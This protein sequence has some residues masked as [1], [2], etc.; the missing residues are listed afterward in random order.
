MRNRLSSVLVA[1]A[2]LALPASQ[3]PLTAG[4]KPMVA[5]SRGELIGRLDRA[6]F[7]RVEALRTDEDATSVE[8]SFE[9]KL[10]RGRVEVRLIDPAG[11][12]GRGSVAD[13]HLVLE[14]GRLPV[15]S[16]SGGKGGEGGTVRHLARRI[17]RHEATGTWAIRYAGLAPA[18]G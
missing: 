7:H 16:D 9:A 8:V 17:H 3:V 13:G 18:A 1:L 2:L 6:S 15:R 14:T 10:E 12:S 4:Q 5:E 11:S